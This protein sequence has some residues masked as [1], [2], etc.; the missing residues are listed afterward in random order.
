MRRIAMTKRGRT[1]V[2]ALVAALGAALGVFVLHP[3]TMVVSWVELR[4]YLAPTG[5]NVFEFVGLRLLASFTL[6]MLPMTA[7]FAAIGAALALVIA[8]VS[9]RWTQ[10]EHARVALARELAQS[11]PSLMEQGESERVEF[12]AALRWDLD[13]GRVNKEIELASL[14]T[15]A[16][17]ANGDGGNL[18][19]GVNDA[20][21]AVGLTRDYGTLRRKDRDG[22]EQHLFTLVSRRIGGDV[23][24]Y[25]HT[26]FGV[27]SGL[28]IVRVVIEPAPR[29]VFVTTGEREQ[30]FVR[31]GNSTRQLG[32]R[33]AVEYI[34]ARWPGGTRP[35]TDTLRRPEPDA[36]A[37]ADIRDVV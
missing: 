12:K 21:C 25:L 28:D 27:V 9:R 17:F 5:N 13:K 29:P 8:F 26:L 19:I 33:E 35:A 34:A 37:T 30:F 22:F 16:G 14:K 2:W 6:P 1:S 32:V 15:I 23:C 24:P 10:A 20:G 11:L 31:T 7:A 36:R 4:E 3:L 18:L